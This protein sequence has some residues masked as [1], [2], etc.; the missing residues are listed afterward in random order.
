MFQGQPLKPLS[1]T[2]DRTVNALWFVVRL[3]KNT[4]LANRGVQIQGRNR[5]S[6]R[7]AFN[8]ARRPFG[9]SPEFTAELARCGVRCRECHL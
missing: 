7:G 6:S 5:H 2:H 8:K 9:G 4:G 1:Y 3:G